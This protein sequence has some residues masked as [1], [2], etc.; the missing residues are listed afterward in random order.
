[1]IYDLR[2]YNA[3]PGKLDT[4]LKIYEEFGLPLQMQYLGR[5]L[6]FTTVEIGPLNQAVHVWPYPS[7]ADRDARRSAMVADPAWAEFRRRAGEAACI[8][9]QECRILKDAPFAAL[10]RPEPPEPKG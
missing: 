9:S 5:P 1:M 4:W 2:I 3:Y 8:S 7:I 10:Q 6:L